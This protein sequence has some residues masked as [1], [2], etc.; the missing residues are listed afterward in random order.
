M[1]NI[2]LDHTTEGDVVILQG[3]PHDAQAL[4]SSAHSLLKDAEDTPF[5]R[6]LTAEADTAWQQLMALEDVMKQDPGRFPDPR[7]VWPT[8]QNHDVRAG[9][10]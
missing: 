4:V 5:V 8:R 2:L 1:N 10:E 3:N 6:S 9:I 7:A